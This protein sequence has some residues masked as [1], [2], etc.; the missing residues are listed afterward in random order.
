MA[1]RGYNRVS[2]GLYR[3]PSGQL[4]PQNKI[5]KP[6]TT[7][8]TPQTQPTTPYYN[9]NLKQ[10][11]R[12]YY[13]M[14]DGRLVAGNA[15]DDYTKRFNKAATEFGSLKQGDAR[16]NEVGNHLKTIGSRYGFDYE[17]VLGKNWAPYQ[18]PTQT[19]APE[20]AQPAPTPAVTAPAA[21]SAPPAIGASIDSY[22]SPMTQSLL[23]AMK[24][25]TNTM[26]AYEPKNFEGS[27]LYQFQKQKGMHD[28]EKLMAAR[29]LTNSGA[30]VQA[31]SDFLAN[32]NAQ[33]AD[34][35]RGFAE[36]EAARNQAMM[37][38]VANYDMGERGALRDQLNT[39]LDRRIGQQQFEANRGDNRNT[40]MTNFLQ[41][42]LQMQ[43]DNNIAQISQAGMGQQSQYS[44]ALMNAIAQFTANNYQR[45]SGGGGGGTPPQAP[46]SPELDIMQILTGYSN[47]AGNNDVLNGFLRT[48]FPR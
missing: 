17:K 11:G 42:I 25:G 21:P 40:L 38:F 10:A 36:N 5:P 14:A 32:L 33:E 43:S 44:Q 18:A 1:T 22:Q 12:G 13:R 23:A 3:S 27:P 34:K 45:Y 31:N 9:T 4:V 47:Q 24:A 20:A 6:T 8:T 2:P 35:Q 16:Y 19:P 37:Q 7:G 28:L 39:D 29:G 15:I 41:N 30:E 48:L 26:A 46:M